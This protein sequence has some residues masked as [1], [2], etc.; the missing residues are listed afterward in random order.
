[1]KIVSIIATFF[2]FAISLYATGINVGFELGYDE[3]TRLSSEW[4][5]SGG[6]AY[7]YLGSLYSQLMLCSVGCLVSLAIRNLLI[8]SIL[9]IA[10][11]IVAIRPLYHI[12]LQNNVYLDSAESFSQLLRDLGFINYVCFGLCI[13]ILGSQIIMIWRHY[14]NRRKSALNVQI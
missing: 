14:R 7:W 1:M 5:V 13:T 3:G 9:C 8:S 11:L 10:S 2:L 4:S 12:R 6:T